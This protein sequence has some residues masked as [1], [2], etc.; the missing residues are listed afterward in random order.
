VGGMGSKMT[1]SSVATEESL[2]TI[3]KYSEFERPD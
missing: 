2:A 1:V 3:W